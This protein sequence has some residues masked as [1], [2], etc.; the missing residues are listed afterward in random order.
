MSTP[1]TTAINS[2]LNELNRTIDTLSR[3]P[4]TDNTA[5]SA[6]LSAGAARVFMRTALEAATPTGDPLTGTPS[7][8]TATPKHQTADYPF[9]SCSP[10]KDKLFSVREGIPQEG[11]LEQASLFLESAQA[12]AG[13]AEDVTPAVVYGA[14]Y[15][16]E[17]AKAIVDATVYAAHAEEMAGAQ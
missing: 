5:D 14:A 9:F 17:M 6:R 3:L 2:A 13:I 10:Q 4:E 15:L 8:A 7:P 12:I 11:A 1:C 16:I